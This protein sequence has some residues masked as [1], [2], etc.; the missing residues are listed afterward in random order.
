MN[1][2]ANRK[3][4]EYLENGKL[5]FEG[6]YLNW[7]RWNGKGRKYSKNGELLFEEEYLNGQK[8]KIQ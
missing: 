7:K 3:G 8:K 4:K 6:E 2:K 5:S 1:G